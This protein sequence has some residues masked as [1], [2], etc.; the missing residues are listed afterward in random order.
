MSLIASGKKLDKSIGPSK[1]VAK[2]FIKET[3]KKK[4]SL[5]S[6]KDEFDE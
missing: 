3:P 2:K 1:D 6:K 4:R 5:F